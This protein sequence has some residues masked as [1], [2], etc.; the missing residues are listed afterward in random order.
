MFALVL[1]ILL[2]L[3]GLA[4]IL[5]A[6]KG[7]YTR[8]TTGYSGSTLTKDIP[9]RWVGVTVWATASVLFLLTF[10]LA[11]LV[12]VGTKQV[13]ILLTFSKPS[14]TLSNGLHLKAPWQD[15]TEMDAAI[16]TDTHVTDTSK[17]NCEGGIP[18]R[19]AHQTV[20]CVDVSI[21]WR[22]KEDAA[23][24]LFQDYRDFDNV[25]NSLVTRELTV[26][27]NEAMKV[28]DPLAVDAKGNSTTPQLTDVANQTLTLMQQS[29]G[30]KVEVLSVLI[31]V[32]HF[33]SNTQGRINALQA[34]I[35]QTRIA[36]QAEQTARAQ[37]A[38]N[39]ALAASVSKDP[40]VIVSKCFDLLQEMVSKGQAF[41]PGFSCWPGGSGVGVIA[42]Q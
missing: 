1:L 23:D 15:V 3:I 18:A 30:G 9:I 11:C 13:G 35:A 40:N 19:I 17:S 2:A 39:Q 34:Q 32:A 28:Y 20:A 41:P 25:R 38:A 27:I 5:I 29:T 8:T 14:G 22:I 16:Q 33:D 4:G 7:T 42:K 10:F 37:S 24:S 31:P 12:I 21:R 36:E 26:A 6:V